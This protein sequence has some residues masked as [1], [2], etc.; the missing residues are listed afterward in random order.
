M[1]P[2]KARLVG[3]LEGIRNRDSRAGSEEEEEF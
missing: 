3:G 1:L 2:L